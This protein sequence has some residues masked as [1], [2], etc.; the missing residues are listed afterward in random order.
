MPL[1]QPP[2]L[3]QTRKLTSR[4]QAFVDAFVSN[5]GDQ[6]AA[7]VSAGYSPA[8]AREQAYGLLGKPHV[9]DEVLRQSYQQLGMQAPQAV[10]RLQRLMGAKSEYVSLM[11]TQDLLDRLGLRA[12]DKI[13][14]RIAGDITV[15]IDL[16]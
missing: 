7:A 13:D 16:S 11:A 6:H 3:T 5:G 14:Q 1:A 15:K 12:P 10:K 2:A 4:Q 9:L 8:T